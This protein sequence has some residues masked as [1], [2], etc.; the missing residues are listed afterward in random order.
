MPANTTPDSVPYPLATEPIR[1][2]AAAIQALAQWIDDAD[3]TDL[4]SNRPAFGRRGR[5]FYATDT[6]Q[7]F[8]DIATGWRI[9]NN[10]RAE[11]GTKAQRE[12]ATKSANI[13]W[14]ETDTGDTWISDGSNWY[15]QSSLAQ[16]EFAAGANSGST[17][18]LSIGP[19]TTTGFGASFTR[20][21]QGGVANGAVEIGKPGLYHV[22]AYVVVAGGGGVHDPQLVF[23]GVSGPAAMAGDAPSGASGRPV[24]LSMVCRAHASF[25]GKVYVSNISGTTAT[26]NRLESLII[27]RVSP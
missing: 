6:G 25:G 10:L 26:Y 22:T 14:V 15:P 23:S 17:G 1:D 19:P 12:A 11:F 24:T 4:A 13:L 9:L 27:R 2:G 16:V 5:I 20:V 18:P 7:A 21:T 8:L 3:I